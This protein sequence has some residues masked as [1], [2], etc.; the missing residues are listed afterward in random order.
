[1][2]IRKRLMRGLGA[3][4][5]LLYRLPVI[6]DPLVRGIGR[7]IAF[8]GHHSSYGMKDG[9][10][11]AALRKDLERA[12]AFM[13]I[14]AAIVHEDGEKLVLALSACPY[15]FDRPGDT[16]VCDAAM[17]QDRAMFGYCG[18]KLV[19]DECIPGGAP[20]CRVSVYLDS[21]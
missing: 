7:F 4:Y 13:D 19:I 6:G 17:E 8:M 18:A 3:A 1:M 20:A 16:G 9:S 15:G 11:I 14:D 2:S 5:R 10:S 21:V 12:L